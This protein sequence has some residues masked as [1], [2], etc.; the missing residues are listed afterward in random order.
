MKQFINPA[1]L[2]ILLAFFITACGDK[3]DD[4][5]QQAPPPTAVS[6]IKATKGSATYYDEF[7]ATVTALLE[8]EIQPQVAGNITGIFF[9][10]GQ[11]I[12]K[13]QK[14]YT[15]DAQQYRAGYDQ[16]VAN[17]NVQKA[18]LNRAQKDADRYNTLAQQDAIARQVVDNASATLEASRM[19]VEAAQANIRQV[20][21]SLKYT[22]IYA[23]LDGTIGISQVRLGAAVAPGS[24][25]LN[26][27][28]S[29]NPIAADLQVDAAEIPRFL[30]LQNQKQVG[31]DSTLVLVMPD[32]STYKYPGSV[33]IVDRAVDPQTGTLRVRVAFPNPDKEL[34]V[35]IN[36]NLRVKNNTGQQQL[37]IPYQAV[38]EQMS[39]YFVFV[40]GD[41]SKVTQKKV[42]LGARINDK[43]IVKDGLKEGEV[44]VTEGTQKIREGAKVQVTSK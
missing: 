27:I 5:Q 25:P 33:R 18:N 14:L 11:Q 10:D 12:R 36:A 21:T 24:V 37:L 38:T 9:Q 4:Q 13:G 7:P 43:V 3:K 15:I 17:L 41:S 31:R 32:G 26:T 39:E 44:V 29:D 30:K 20:A 35:G 34:K 8:V 16:A 22:T 28:S 6:A 19:Q 23:P 40:V 1:T 2:V 42:T